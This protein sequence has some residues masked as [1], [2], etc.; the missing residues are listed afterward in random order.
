MTDVRQNVSFV[1]IG[2]RS[3]STEIC[4]DCQQEP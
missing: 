1:Q 3:Y 4:S 2:L